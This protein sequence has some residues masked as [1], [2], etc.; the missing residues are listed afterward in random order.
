MIYKIIQFKNHSSWKHLLGGSGFRDAHA[1]TPAARHGCAFSL[2]N[3]MF[4]GMYF[5]FILGLFFIVVLVAVLV[6]PLH[7][8]LRVIFEHLH[9]RVVPPLHVMFHIGCLPSPAPSRPV[10]H[11]VFKP[12]VFI[13]GLFFIL[14]LVAVLA[15]PLHLLLRV[16]LEHLLFRVVPPIH[17]KFHICDGQRMC[18][19]RSASAAVGGHSLRLQ[20][21][22]YILCLHRPPPVPLGLRC[23]A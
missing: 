17:A 20:I 8:L 19:L 5:V 18:C 1:S 14:V 10:R 15:V 7:L 22:P 9:L 2:L 23:L 11:T 16:I 4:C 21:G 6:V 12:V 3:L 13:L